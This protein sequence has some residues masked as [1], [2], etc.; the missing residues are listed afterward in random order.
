ME[1]EEERDRSRP[2]SDGIRKRIR[3]I[4]SLGPGGLFAGRYKVLE[5]LGS[6]G[7]GEV[8]RALDTT[9]GIDVA[10]K[11]LY[12]GAEPSHD[13][14][15]LRRE[16]R[17]LR[18]LRHPGIVKI[19]DIGEVDGVLYAVSELLE[20]ES[21]A[22]RLRRDGA[23]PAGEAERILRRVLEALATAH[24]A[25]VVHRDIKPANIFLASGAR[26]EARSVLL[27][28]FGLARSSEDSSLTATGHF[29][30]TPE[31]CAPEQVR[32][33]TAVSPATDLYACGITLWAMLSGK[34][35]FRGDSQF[36]VL[37][38][39]VNAPPP[40]AKREMPHAPPRLRAF[41]L[42]CLEKTVADRPPD[43]AEAL[44]MLD[45]PVSL[46]KRGRFLR[47]AARRF[48]RRKG[49]LGL[50]A[51][52]SLAALAAVV[53]AGL[54]LLTPIGVRHQG[55]QVLWKTR[56]GWEIASSPFEQPV[57]SIR[58][59]GSWLG[60]FGKAYVGVW[61]QAVEGKP[62][63][64]HPPFPPMLYFTRN[65]LAGARPVFSSGS[66]RALEEGFYPNFDPAYVPSTLLDVPG[67]ALGD[68]PRLV[69]DA[70]HVV[71]SPA[72]LVGSDETGR[73]WFTYDHP[74]LLPRLATLPRE[75]GPPLIIAAGTNYLLG[76]RNVVVA[77]PAAELPPGQ[78]PPYV[79]P[80][81]REETSAYYLFLPRVTQFDTRLRLEGETGV[82]E[83]EGRSPLRFHAATGIPTEASDRGGL[84]EQAWDARRR[85]LLEAL[86]KAS[87]LRDA[88]QSEAGARLLEDFAAERVGSP[89]LL[90]VALYRAARI[91][92]R[93]AA[94][95][96]DPRA[97][98]TAIL[99]Q[100]LDDVARAIA[101]ESQ[102]RVPSH[103]QIN[104]ADLLLR[105]GR[106]S[107]ARRILDDW[108]TGPSAAGD[109]YY[110]WMLLEWRAGEDPPLSRVL[111]SL[112]DDSRSSW[113]PLI[114]LAYAVHRADYATGRAEA[115]KLNARQV[116][117]DTQHY[118]AARIYLDGT[119]PDPAAALAHLDRAE[120]SFKTGFQLPLVAASLRAKLLLDP[121]HPPDA[122]AVERARRDLDYTAECAAASVECLAMLEYGERDLAAVTAANARA[123]KGSDIT[124]V[125][126]FA[127]WHR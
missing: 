79:G 78:G 98:R 111:A 23:L 33:R 108:I 36:D 6:G 42:A 49:A 39:H 63:R 82:V 50:L 123:Q 87:D 109:Y 7:A 85:R 38:A 116:Q 74:G 25:G 121:A 106:A 88:G 105:L 57:A 81:L 18:S 103:Y 54:W 91:R 75:S 2:D 17:I 99:E 22:E 118:W 114:R 15:R 112:P 125:T 77:L 107:E 1:T 70:V 58:M 59:V 19:F 53:Y 10:L 30:G 101:I 69:L 37:N 48:A 94:M 26:E 122:S 127:G 92:M 41:A 16:V 119:N 90:S 32:G 20:G 126:R 14:E 102:P 12:P 44:R 72:R 76:P 45:T 61:S 9:A 66:A 46:W 64:A 71:S 21:L 110:S 56:S 95:P 31:Y 47:S 24:A 8:Y 104:Q 93:Q 3:R 89:E 100:A 120:E 83:L 5:S 68:G 86:F 113:P 13:L 117:L 35:P 60:P 52:M 62:W 84:S 4:A 40:P 96:D 124:G 80:H 73:I 28:D 55:K 97:S 67:V 43:A 11:I 27:L 51:A 29:V 65:V 115:E 34:P